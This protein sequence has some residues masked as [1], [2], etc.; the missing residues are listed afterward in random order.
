MEDVPMMKAESLGK[1]YK[2]TVEALKD[3]SFSVE[4]GECVGYLGPNGAGKSTTIKIFT[5]L[6]RPTGGRAVL[7]GFD[8]NREP[9]KALRKTGSLVEVPGL[10]DYLTPR[11]LMSYIGKIYGMHNRDIEQRTEEVMKALGLS[12]WVDHHLRTFSTGMRRR[13]SIGQAVIHDPDLVI[14]DEPV[15]GLDPSGI[16]DIRHFLQRLKKEDKSVFLSSHLLGEVEE[17][18][19]RVLLINR[20]KILAEERMSDLKRSISGGHL[21]LYSQPPSEGEMERIR[22]LE[23]VDC[24]EMDGVQLKVLGGGVDGQKLALAALVEGNAQGIW[25]IMPSLEEL[26]VRVIDGHQEEVSCGGEKL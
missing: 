12:E 15:L 24:V 23:G 10:Y 22:S 11:E 21:I 5:T 2:G 6:I 1:R 20:G 25:P 4:R 18:S 17:V 14:L 8:V 7:G 13:Y 16:R 26:Y 3:A 9:K 19:D